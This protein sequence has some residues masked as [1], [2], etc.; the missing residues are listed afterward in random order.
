MAATKAVIFDLWGCVQIPRPLHIFHKYEESL[1]LPRDFIDKTIMNRGPESAL[2]RA[3]LGKLTLSQMILQLEVECQKEVSRQSLS[4]P[5][6]FSVQKLFDEVREALRFNT[7]IL[8]ASA[9]LRNHGVVTCVLAQSWVDDSEQRA[10]TAQTLFILNTHFDLVLQ[11]CRVGA[12]LPDSALFNHALQRLGATPQQVIFVGAEEAN[13]IAARALGMG[14]VLM[15]DPSEAIKQ[16]QALSGVELLSSD[17]ICPVY[18]NPEEV[19]HCSVSIKPG[20]QTHLVDVGE[21]PAVLLC[22]GFP[23]SWFS[24]RYQIPALA[25][26]GFRVLV[27]DMKGYGDS[28]APP[29]IEEYSQEQICQD[30]LTLMDKLGIPQVTLVGHDWGG[31]LVWNMAQCHPERVRAVGSLNTP[32]FPVDPNS[33]P[34][35]KLKATPIFNYQIYFQQP[36]V[37][38]AEMEKDLERTFK[39]MFTGSL[40]KG[41]A[42][43]TDNV[44]ERGGLFVGLPDDVPRSSILSE[45]ALK[46]YVQQYSKSG[47]RGPLNWYRNVERNWSW[48][49]SRPRGKILMPALM[50][51]AGKD[52]VLLPVFTTGM[53]NMVP[54]LTRGH[55][56][57]CGHW[58]QMERPAELNKILLSWLKDVHEKAAIPVSPKL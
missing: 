58:T 21:G 45:S 42:I 2:H 55:I 16:M 56:E 50:V 46:Y 15:E 3:G 8:Q 18:Y 31:V 11:S 33:N 53:E 47:F 4:L 32:L 52:P 13:V 19:P 34:M 10:D 23:E 37:A 7:S 20:V 36:G 49:C 1:G 25:D 35:E 43:S 30:L 48:L 6:Q 38:E 57:Q 12:R 27:P 41:L 24:W 17:E 26:A 22:H 9:K 39:I 44:C 54:N 14:V 5:P 28:S 40:D 51:T 29:E